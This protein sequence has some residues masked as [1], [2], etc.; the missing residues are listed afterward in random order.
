M[1]PLVL[2]HGGSF[3]ASCWDLVVEQLGGPALAVD[4][5]GRGT[6]PAPLATVTIETAAASVAADVD[7]AGFD[8]IV[9]VGH[10]LAGDC[11]LIDL[12]A[13]HMCMIS[14]PAEVA[15]FLQRIADR[16]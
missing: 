15:A 11:E 16:P 6:H 4:L 13:G 12:D 7:A 3:A 8:D 5:P 2:V 1:T 14:K 9:L 10:S